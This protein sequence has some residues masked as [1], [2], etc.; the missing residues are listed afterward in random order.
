MKIRSLA[1]TAVATGALGLVGCGGDDTTAPGGGGASSSTDARTLL[2][3]TFKPTG[4]ASKIKSGAIEIKLQ[5]D[6]TGGSM[7]GNGEATANI[8]LAEAKDGEVPEFSAAVKV[9][10]EQKGGQKIDLDAGGVYTDKRFYVS[11]DGE[12]YDVGEELSGR[13]LDSLQAAIKQ[14]ADTGGASQDELVGKLGL[15]PEKWLTDPKVEG[16]EEIG[17]VDTYKITGAVD[18]KALV[19]DVLEAAKKAQ[20]FAGSKAPNAT[21]PEITDAQLDQAA[22][23]IKTLDVAIWTG[24]DDTILRKLEVDLEIAGTKG[25]QVTGTASITLTDVNEEQDIQAPSNTKPITD[26]MP[27]LGG[28]FGAAA[29]ASPAAGSPSG[30]VSDAYIKCVGD[31][32]GDAAKLNACQ[33]QLQK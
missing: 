6:L 4:D 33:A 12:D 27:K 24:K 26:L 9:K 31:A 28:L 22:K 14:S 8:K 30:A 18:V 11:Y 19:P 15:E 29:G 10:G 23:Q 2:V 13:A 21:V 3:N 5:G 7:E 16:E 20:S 32:N 25:D 1:L 17:G